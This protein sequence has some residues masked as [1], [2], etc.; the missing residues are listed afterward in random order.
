MGSPTFFASGSPGGGGGGRLGG[1]S[2]GSLM[3]DLEGF[4]CSDSD[5]DWQDG[6]G[7]DSETDQQVGG[8]RQRVFINHYRVGV[9][10]N[11]S[12]DFKIGVPVLFRRLRL[13]LQ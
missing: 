3:A 10:N 8:P 7:S 11:V 6:A 5:D 4:S 9:S 13:Q 1:A 2:A 12:T